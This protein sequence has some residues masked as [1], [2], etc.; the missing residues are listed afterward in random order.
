MDS[1]QFIDQLQQQTG[2]D[3]KQVTEFVA[4]INQIIRDRAVL[5]DIVS[6]QGFGAFEPRKKRERI[7]VSPSTGKRMLIPPKMTVIFK[8]SVTIKNRLKDL[9]GHE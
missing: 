5:M 4:G 1:K 2:F 6:I 7:S 8:P 3:K 9:P